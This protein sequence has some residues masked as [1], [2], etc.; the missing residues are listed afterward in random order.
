MNLREVGRGHGLHSYE[1]VRNR[2][3]AVVDTAM[4]SIRMRWEGHTERIGD[5]YRCFSVES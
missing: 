4:K 2:W 3:W 1:Q 5:V